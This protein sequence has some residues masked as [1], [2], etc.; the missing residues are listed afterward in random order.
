LPL[1]V[2]YIEESAEPVDKENYL[3]CS[4]TIIKDN[5]VDTKGKG[6]IKLR[7][8]KTMELKKKT[9]QNKV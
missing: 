8:N 3:T 4:I 6:K 7:G 2:I 9:L 5:K 1:V